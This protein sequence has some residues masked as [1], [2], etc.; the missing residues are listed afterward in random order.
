MTKVGKYQPTSASTTTTSCSLKLPSSPLKRATHVN[1]TELWDTRIEP[2]TKKYLDYC[3]SES[4]LYLD[5][6]N[7]RNHAMILRKM[8]KANPHA[9][10]VTDMF[11]AATIEAMLTGK[12]DGTIQNFTR[13]DY[14]FILKLTIINKT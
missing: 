9:T 7:T 10:H 5:S 8:S 6:T 11:T 3:T 12:N 1:E 14:L 4:G 13:Y 2:F